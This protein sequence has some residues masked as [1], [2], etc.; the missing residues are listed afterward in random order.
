MST[1]HAATNPF[2][3]PPDT[4]WRTVLPIVGVPLAVE[5]FKAPT[6]ENVGSVNNDVEP[7]EVGFLR[8]PICEKLV[9]VGKSLVVEV[10]NLKW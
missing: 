3:V 1:S 6:D 10:S 8:I 9:F 7:I 5:N 4:T 2:A